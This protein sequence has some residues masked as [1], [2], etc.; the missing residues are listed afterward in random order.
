M[1]M[2]RSLLNGQKKGTVNGGRAVLDGLPR[3]MSKEAF[4][5]L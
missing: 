3:R 1:E 5:N 2:E 4:L